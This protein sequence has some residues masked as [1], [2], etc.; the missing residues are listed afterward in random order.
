MLA[1][2]QILFLGE[3]LEDDGQEPEED[4]DSLSESDGTNPRILAQSEFPVPQGPDKETIA[5][6]QSSD[7][8]LSKVVDRSNISINLHRKS[9]NCSPPMTSSMLIALSTSN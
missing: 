3:A 1:D 6:Q 5:D 7:Q 2:D 9:T 8:T 4:C